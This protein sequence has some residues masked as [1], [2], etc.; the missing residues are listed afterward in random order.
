[1]NSKLL[2]AICVPIVITITTISV[3]MLEDPKNMSS[4]DDTNTLQQ[5][6]L[7]PYHGGNS[8]NGGNMAFYEEWCVQNKGMWDTAEDRCGFKTAKDHNL[9]RTALDK[10]E[11]PDVDGDTAQEICRFLD[12]SCPDHATF[13]GYYDATEGKTFVNYSY[14]GVEYKFD[15][16]EQKIKYKTGDSDK[17]FDINSETVNING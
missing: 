10:L 13:P 14:K 8:F 6:S 11:H 9:A 16:T 1:M 15:V 2:A 3:I 12:M 4:L 17:W 5:L 7:E